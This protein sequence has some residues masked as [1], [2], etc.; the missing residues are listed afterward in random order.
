L[1][2]T[3]LALATFGLAVALRAGL[4]TRRTELVRILLQ[5]APL[6]LPSDAADWLLPNGRP[7]LFEGYLPSA[8]G[9]LLV[10]LAGTREGHATGLAYFALG[11]LGLAAFIGWGHGRVS[12]PVAPVLTR[13]AAQA[14]QRSI[15]LSATG[16]TDG[17]AAALALAAWIETLCRNVPDLTIEQ[18]ESHYTAYQVAGMIEAVLS[19]DSN[20]HKLSKWL[21]QPTRALF[22]SPEEEIRVTLLEGARRELAG[23]L[24]PERAREI[25]SQLRQ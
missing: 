4:V 12:G 6:A 13:Y 15:G 9:V 25:I 8:I 5:R 16:D 1:W 14:R 24:T 2:F 20:G 22:A 19:G 23:E 17:E 7:R 10:V 11:V 3:G 18:L 21:E